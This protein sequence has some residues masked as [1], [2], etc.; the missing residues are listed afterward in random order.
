MKTVQ[1]GFTLIELMIVIAIIGILASVALPAYS[2]YTNKAAFSEVVLASSSVKSEVEVCAQRADATNA[3]YITRCIGGGGFGVNNRG[4]SG[5]VTS[6]TS[7]TPGA[8]QV[9]ITATGDANFTPASP[10]YIT[11]G[12]RDATTGQV[13]WDDITT[14]GSCLAANLC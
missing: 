9:A 11:T 10:T 7:A 14:P 12:T 13:I 4:A 6:V 1:Q 8:A 5:R 2:N 3:N